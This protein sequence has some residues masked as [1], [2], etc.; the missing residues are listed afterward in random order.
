MQ[1][2]RR[3][4]GEQLM[5]AYVVTMYVSIEAAT[6]EEAREIAFSLEV[7]PKNE[8]DREKIFYD[9]QN[10]EVDEPLV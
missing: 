5:N 1:G 9:A 3:K 4:W 6:E 2:Y 8:A 10:S 7:V